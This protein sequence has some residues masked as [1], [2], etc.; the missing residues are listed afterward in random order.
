MF[1]EDKIFTGYLH[2]EFSLFFYRKYWSFPKMERKFSKFRESTNQWSMNWGQFK[3]PVSH[4]CVAGAVVPSWSL[5]LVAA[6]SNLFDDKFN[7]NIWRKLKLPHRRNY[8][9][10]WE[11]F[12]CLE[13]NWEI[14]II[15]IHHFKVVNLQIK[16]PALIA[17]YQTYFTLPTITFPG[18]S[19]C[20]VANIADVEYISGK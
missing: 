14:I 4:L 16:H 17:S 6:G 18:F 5:T 12:Y 13:I 2:L 3:D 9:W 7:E 15:W 19:L 20:T 11:V 8:P 10:I 1:L